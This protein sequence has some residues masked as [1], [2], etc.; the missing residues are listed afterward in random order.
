MQ[1]VGKNH[2]ATGAGGRSASP[3]LSPY[4]IE[5]IAMTAADFRRMRVGG[6]TMIVAQR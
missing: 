6:P 4:F 3:R 1:N 2:P 5:D